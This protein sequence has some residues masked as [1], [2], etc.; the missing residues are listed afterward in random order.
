VNSKTIRVTSIPKLKYILLDWN[1]IK[2]LKEPRP[3]KYSDSIMKESIESLRDKYYFPFCESHLRDLRQSFKQGYEDKVNDDL[4]FLQELSKGVMVLPNESLNC[5]AKY[6][7]REYF[8]IILEEP[9]RS[10][11]LIPKFHSSTLIDMDKLGEEHP[12]RPLLMK[13]GGILSSESFYKWLS[14]MFET[15]F[16]EPDTYCKTR[17]YVEKNYEELCSG[18]T[19]EPYGKLLMECTKPF[20]ES[21]KIKTKDELSLV[22]KNVVHSWLRMNFPNSSPHPLEELSVSYSLLDIHPL[23]Q[24]RM[25]SKNK[26]DNMVRDSKLI[27]YASSS[28]YFVTEDKKCYDKSKFIYKVYGYKTKVVKIEEFV[29]RFS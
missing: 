22:W 20:F 11:E 7:V 13:T 25:N 12:L 10:I 24:E 21:F 23:F 9:P 1:V 2:Y 28:E 16:D 27:C 15:F 29:R 14:E 17:A 26:L 4:D 19:T 5:L 18:N 3:G 8:N 6:S